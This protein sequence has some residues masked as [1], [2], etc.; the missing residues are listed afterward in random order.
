MNNLLLKRAFEEAEKRLDT[1]VPTKL[2]KHLSDFIFNDVGEQYGERILR[3]KYN[4][5]KENDNKRVSLKSFAKEALSHFIGYKSY[6][7]F[8]KENVKEDLNFW[9]WVKR[10]KVVITI[11]ISILILSIFI[12]AGINTQ[13]W[14]VWQEN[15][16]IEVKFDLEKYDVDQLKLY[17]QERIDNFKK[18]IPDCNTDFFK[19][20][21]SENLWYGKNDKGELEYFTDLGLHPET[22]K[23]LKKITIYMIRKYICET[24]N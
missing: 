7:Q 21:G 15:H 14:M 6:A 19:P 8:V 11:S 23:T 18:I 9:D 5:V 17:R 2:A 24:Y 12:I 4:A 10:K 13:K 3:D 22:G 1:D 20:D 16:Y